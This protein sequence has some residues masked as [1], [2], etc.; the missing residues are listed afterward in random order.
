MYLQTSVAEFSFLY[1]RVVENTRKPE[2]VSV[3]GYTEREKEYTHIHKTKQD[4]T[5]G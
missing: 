1:S 3:R 2:T 5:I 4:C